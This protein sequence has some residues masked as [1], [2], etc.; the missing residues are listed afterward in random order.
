MTIQEL[1]QKLSKVE[2]K[3]IDSGLHDNMSIGSL[4]LVLHADGS[5]L[6]MGDWMK[7]IENP[8]PEQRLL[9]NIFTDESEVFE[10]NEIEELETWINQKLET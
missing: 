8:T 7:N 3:I 5:G 9:T 6:V 10:F 1:V 2:D 4:K